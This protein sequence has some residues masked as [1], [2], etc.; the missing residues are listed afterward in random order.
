MV[1]PE[2]IER[3][4]KKLNKEDKFMYINEQKYI[5]LK[6]KL[7]HR[8]ERNKQKGEKLREDIDRLSKHG[9]WDMGY[10]KGRESAFR[11]I[12]DYLEEFLD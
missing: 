12:L 4:Y 11:D 5:K 7:I 1:E 8:M 2:Q 6:E 9:Y 3:A 10:F